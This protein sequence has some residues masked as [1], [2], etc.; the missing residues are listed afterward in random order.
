MRRASFILLATAAYFFI[1]P[2][3]LT[4]AEKR[5]I[6]G[7]EVL[8]GTWAT[9]LI[10]WFYGG[11][12]VFATT[13]GVVRMALRERTTWRNGR[14][15]RLGSGA[16]HM[17]RDIKGDAIFI[18]GIGFV[19]LGHAIGLVL[20]LFRGPAVPAPLGSYDLV[21]LL[22]FFLPFSIVSIVFTTWGLYGFAKWPTKKQIIVEQP[23]QLP[24]MWVQPLWPFRIALPG[25]RNFIRAIAP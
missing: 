23:A 6:A 7:G 5:A 8:F 25:M 10:C 18:G 19:F 21:W 9:Y 17:H 16:P 4:L 1:S 14:L 15:F 20:L 2:F 24:P 22:G 12:I 11:V 3:F 13:I